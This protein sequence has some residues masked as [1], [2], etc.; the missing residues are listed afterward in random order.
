MQLV[1]V[2]KMDSY[3]S[4]NPQITFY[5]AVH[6]RH[7]NFAIECVQQTFKEGGNFGEK[8]S[9]VLSRKGDLIHRIYL[10]VQLPPLMSNN[11]Y[12]D[13]IGHFLIKEVS[14]EIG[15]Q[16][17]ERHYGEWLEVWNQ[18][19]QT[20]ER[21]AGYD[22]MIGASLGTSGGSLYIPFQFWFCKNPGLSLPLIALAYHEIKINVE[23]RRAE[24]C[25]VGSGPAPSMLN[26]ML[27]VDYIYLDSEERKHFAQTK[28]HEYLI[29]QV[30]TIE[31]AHNKPNIMCEL[32]FNHPCKELIWVIQSKAMELSKDWFNYSR[33]GNTE[34][35]LVDACLEINGAK[36]F[37]K[38]RGDYFNLVQPYQHHTAVPSSGVY[39]YSF[40]L[41]PEQHQ[42]S[43]TLNVSRI[44]TL[45][46]NL[47]TTVTG[48][49]KLRV[50]AVNY[51][52][53]RVTS[54]MGGLLFS[55]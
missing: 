22:K 46:L 52:I 29:E 2:G 43:G 14:I 37:E 15:G 53:F 33:D 45:T 12:V 48:Q 13:N 27:F 47:K 4:E 10:H 39:V 8:V 36:R 17:I 38:T 41:H 23:F 51:N 44:D 32:P 9:C 18:L 11:R 54:G 1:A 16:V 28:E 31:E 50:Y 49:Y 42:P 25:F 24:D 40:A 30:Q 7:T 34:G 35:T 19:T 26:A 21:S 55:T 5:K 20:A 3:L 6:R